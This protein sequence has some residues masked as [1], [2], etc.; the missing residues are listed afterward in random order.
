MYRE[1]LK[2][3]VLAAAEEGKAFIQMLIRAEMRKQTKYHVHVFLDDEGSVLNAT[4][5]ERLVEVAVQDANMW[6]PVCMAWSP[7]R[8]RKN[9]A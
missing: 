1:G 6:P 7:W 3:S 4:V 8:G 9:E 5:S 2:K